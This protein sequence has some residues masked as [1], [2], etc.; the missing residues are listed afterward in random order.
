MSQIDWASENE[1]DNFRSLEDIAPLEQA[2][3]GGTPQRVGGYRFYFNG[4]RWEWSPEV[5]QIHGYQPGTVTP[6]TRLVLS[7]KHPTTT[8]TSRRHSTTSAEPTSRSAPATASSASRA[9]PATS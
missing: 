1:P 9:P 5:E 8:N 6:T 7:P 3:T 4:E 2:L